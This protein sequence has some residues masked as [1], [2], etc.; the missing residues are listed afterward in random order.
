[1]ARVH[2]VSFLRVIYLKLVPLSP[3]LLPHQIP[4]LTRSWDP[5]HEI[6]HHYAI[7][8]SASS[9]DQSVASWFLCL[10]CRIRCSLRKLPALLVQSVDFHHHQS[11]WRF[12][13]V[14]PPSNLLPCLVSPFIVERSLW[15]ECLIDLG[16]AFHLSLDRSWPKEY[17][18][19]SEPQ[20][21]L[22]MACLRLFAAWN[23]SSLC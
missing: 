4:H 18:P 14:S 2:C 8:K 22:L 9:V 20:V 19:F 15:A 5:P 1:M 21:A 7:R 10:R 3:L 16:L 12:G 6:L 23:T 11:T 13:G 17:L